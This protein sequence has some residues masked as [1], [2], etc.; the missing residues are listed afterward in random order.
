[1]KLNS[2]AKMNK[3]FANKVSFMSISMGIEL[4]MARNILRWQKS[5]RPSKKNHIFSDPKTGMP[6]SVEQWTGPAQKLADK[7]RFGTG[8][9]VGDYATAA[10]ME[11]V[12]ELFGCKWVDATMLGMELVNGTLYSAGELDEMNANYSNPFETE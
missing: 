6:L 2:S 9:T 5:Q 1:M 8:S 10:F 3:D 11:S 7:V 12:P 4:H